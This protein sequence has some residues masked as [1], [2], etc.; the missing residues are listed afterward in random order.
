MA[1]VE[2]NDDSAL[3]KAQMDRRWGGGGTGDHDEALG[4]LG[5]TF[6]QWRARKATV[7]LSRQWRSYCSVAAELQASGGNG[8]GTCELVD[9]RVGRAQVVAGRARASAARGSVSR[10]RV[11]H[12]RRLLSDG[13]QSL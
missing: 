1:V 11:A 10:R 9:R 13:D 3:T 6:S 12:T 8:N 2:E 4:K 7:T 5:N